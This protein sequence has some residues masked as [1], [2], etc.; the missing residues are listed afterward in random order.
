[1]YRYLLFQY[2]LPYRV[3]ADDGVYHVLSDGVLWRITLEAVEPPA[4]ASVTPQVHFGGRSQ[5]Y[6]DNHGYSGVTK[7]FVGYPFNPP[8]SKEDYD[9]LDVSPN[10]ITLADSLRAVNRL[11]SVYRAQTNEFWLRPLGRADVPAYSWFLYLTDSEQ[12]EWAGFS[13]NAEIAAG[14]PYLK[15]EAWY[16]NLLQRFQ[17]D[18][19]L[20]FALE[21]IHE[22][23]DALARDNLRL[24]AADFALAAEALF[25]GLVSGF[26]PEE[27]VTRP[28]EQM[29]GTYFRRY[30]EIGDPAALPI[31]KRNALQLFKAVWVPRDLLMHGHDLQLTR[32]QVQDARDAILALFQ[33]WRY[34]PNAPVMLVEGPFALGPLSS[35]TQRL[36]FPSRRPQDHLERAR[37]RYRG[38][39][40]GD[41]AEAAQFALVLD[42]K[43]LDAIMLLG[44][45][46]FEEGRFGSAAEWF[47]KAVELDP[48]FLPAVENLR[49]SRAVLQANPDDPAAK[50]L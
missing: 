12:L 5:L 49:I 29:M 8:V 38:G 25:R 39:H 22:G 48:D 34:R 1:M 35:E 47:Q 36:A 33:L 20:P 18:E 32:E 27:D 9:T 44:A 4:V 30:R 2:Q 37:M 21:L 46:S 42:N 3:F 16:E 10:R 24:A 40:L 50:D 41:A 45:I 15:R 13:T 11:I 14:Y 7:V 28:A 26:F 23:Q 17:T 19:P 31:R 43:N 6:L